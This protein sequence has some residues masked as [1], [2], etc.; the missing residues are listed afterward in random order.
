VVDL[1]VDVEA[2][3]T[4]KSRCE[5]MLAS[6]AELSDYLDGSIDAIGGDKLRGAV[7]SFDNKWKDGKDKLR[8][9]MEGM[10]ERVSAAIEQ[11]EHTEAD[12]SKQ[13][14]EAFG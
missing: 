8:R 9:Q 14:S 12:L 3:K 13:M 5:Q 2:L 1:V 4:L 10:L 7:H 6:L 11:Y